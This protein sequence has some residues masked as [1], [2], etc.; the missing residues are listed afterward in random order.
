MRDLNP[1]LL[2]PIRSRIIQY[3]GIHKTA[4]AGELTSFMSDVPRTTLYRHLNVLA[5]HTVIKVVAENRVRGAV[6]RTYALDIQSISEANSLQNTL[7]NAFGFLITIYGNWAAYFDKPYPDPG[8]DKLFLSNLNLLLSD[9]EFDAFLVQLNTL[10]VKH[11]NNTPE[12]GRK[13][14]SISIVSS[15]VM[16]E[17]EQLETK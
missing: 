16:D 17:V 13:Q 1:I 4:T 2:H 15:P 3:L 14:R 12:T 9:V 8:R 5:E 6:E 11:L 10:L 7:R